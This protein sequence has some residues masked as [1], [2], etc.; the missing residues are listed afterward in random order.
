M[1]NP[2]LP[3]TGIIPSEEGNICFYADGYS[4]TLIDSSIDPLRSIE[5][6]P[7]ESFIW[8]KTRNGNDIAIYTGLYPAYTYG[9]GR[10]ESSAYAIM[11]SNTDST[12]NNSF[13]GIDFVGGTL[14]KVYKQFLFR[15]TL[16][17]YDQRRYIQKAVS[18]DGLTVT[19]IIDFGIVFGRSVN[20]NEETVFV[21]MLFSEKQPLITV[22]RHYNVLKDLI[23]FM[24]F[25]R[26][27]G[28]DDIV[29]LSKTEGDHAEVNDYKPIGNVFIKKSDSLTEKRAFEG[30]LF[31][32]I[33]SAL[34]NFLTVLYNSKEREYLYADGF[35]PFNDF[36]VLRM[37]DARIREICSAIECELGF[38]E[39]ENNK[40]ENLMALIKSVTA[41]VKEHREGDNPLPQKTYDNIFGSIAH[42]SAATSDRIIALYSQYKQI[43]THIR[44]NRFGY[45]VNDKAIEKFIQYRNDITHGKFRMLNEDVARTAFTMMGLVYCCVLKRI[46]LDEEQIMHLNCLPELLL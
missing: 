2:N 9:D 42:W 27:V 15:A 7:K 13:W 18:I 10:M 20:K 24:M 44:P 1:K 29:L 21:R 28:F 4:F 37:T 38:I 31:E 25:R 23:S 33:E 22:L 40:D 41:I 16:G 14:N 30:I 43:I 34:P 36:T 8:G 39:Q 6:L 11:A 26:N 45:M 32:E 19:I 17:N 3:I 46:G 12:E 5:V 35:L